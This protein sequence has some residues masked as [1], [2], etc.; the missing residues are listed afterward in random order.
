MRRCLI[1]DDAV[2]D[3]EGAISAYKRTLY[4][5]EPIEYEPIGLTVDSQYNASFSLTLESVLQ[6]LDSNHYDLFACDMELGFENQK[7]YDI[8][9]VVCKKYSSLPII[10]YSGDFSSLAKLLADRLYKSNGE[11]AKNILYALTHIKKIVDRAENLEDHILNVLNGNVSVYQVIQAKLLENPEMVLKIGFSSFQGKT[12]GE[13][14][15]ILNDE[16]HNANVHRF[17]EDLIEH[18]LHHLG[19]LNTNA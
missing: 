13:I 3:I 15:S 14:A 5:H 4:N 17:I 11:D 1:L 2:A 7:G 18:A 8:L 12:F 9:Q 10:L 6:S 19:Q 16:K